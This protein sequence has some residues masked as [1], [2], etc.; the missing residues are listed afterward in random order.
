MEVHNW[1]MNKN[2]GSK[3]IQMNVWNQIETNAKFEHHLCNS[4]FNFRWVEEW[5][6]HL[7][8]S[9]PTVLFSIFCSNFV[10]SST[11]WLVCFVFIL[12][13][14][15]RSLIIDSGNT[16][17]FPFQNFGFR[18][19]TVFCGVFDGHGPHGHKVARTVRDILP[20][21]LTS[22]WENEE[23]METSASHSGSI[24]SDASST[25]PK[26]EIRAS[27]A[28]GEKN[29]SSQIFMSLK[30]SLLMAFRITDKELKQNPNIDCSYSGTTAV[31]LVKQVN[32][33]YLLINILYK[34]TS[35]DWNICCLVMI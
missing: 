31:T 24:T 15:I 4:P 26:E 20:V 19:D 22:N 18:N 34:A 6:F 29:N 5:I 12:G 35:F 25:L 33:H 9:L 3:L 14:I 21:K 7:F 13:S 8:Q 2:L 16:F 11:C 30:D 27:I 1:N 17:A 32:Y 28:I 23:L 10:P